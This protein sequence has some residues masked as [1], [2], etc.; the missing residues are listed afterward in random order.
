MILLSLSV[1]GEQVSAVLE[2]D[3]AAPQR[4]A[5]APMRLSEVDIAHVLDIKSEVAAAVAGYVPTHHLAVK[6]GRILFDGLLG[7]PAINTLYREGIE[8]VRATRRDGNAA[9][10]KCSRRA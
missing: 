8:T 4:H 1:R 7:S 5:A 10:S 9:E 3:A 2:S 6:A